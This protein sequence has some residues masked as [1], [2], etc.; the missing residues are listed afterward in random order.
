[1]PKAPSP[2]QRPAPA[3]QR[4]GRAR[5]VADLLPDIG[6]AAFRRFGFVQ[7]SVV[8]RWAEIVGDRFA[9][10]SQPESLRFPRGERTGGVLTLTVIPA[11]GTMMQ[12]VAPEIVE[13]VNR[14]FGYSAV[15]RIVF[16]PGRIVRPAAPVA[17][18][19]RPAPAQPVEL[20]ENVRGIA[21]AEL[22][23]VLEALAAGIGDAPAPL[24]FGKIS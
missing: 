22:R 19:V 21:D 14:F 13:R 6:R 8:S 2:D 9:R 24:P 3:P 7:S 16:T 17:A 10:V 4:G 1:M 18:P 12:H 15:A 11:H 23:T 20:A 5:A